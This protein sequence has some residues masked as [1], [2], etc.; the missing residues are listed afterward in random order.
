M[1]KL[2]KNDVVMYRGNPVRLPPEQAPDLD[3]NLFLRSVWWD[4]RLR[5][6]GD[7][8]AVE[9]RPFGRCPDEEFPTVWNTISQVTGLNI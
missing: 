2:V 9:M 3:P 6:F 4:Y 5:R 7:S 1:D 8:L